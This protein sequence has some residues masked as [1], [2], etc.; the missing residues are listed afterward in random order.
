MIGTN[1]LRIRLVIPPKK[2]RIMVWEGQV[3][4]E[5]DGFLNSA[6]VLEAASV[7]RILQD[8]TSKEVI[9]CIGKVSQG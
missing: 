1:L 8:T 3:V 4:K 5:A 7:G 9:K 6:S 2:E